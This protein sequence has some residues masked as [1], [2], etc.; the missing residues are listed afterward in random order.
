M[1]DGF[2]GGSAPG[3]GACKKLLAAPRAE[4]VVFAVRVLAS[5]EMRG[6]AE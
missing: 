2:K 4:A 6:G 5:R 3:L 1:E